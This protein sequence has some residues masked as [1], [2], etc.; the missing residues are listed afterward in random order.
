MYAQINLSSITLPG[1]IVSMWKY[2][3]R[4]KP[5]SLNMCHIIEDCLKRGFGDRLLVPC[6]G[7]N[8]YF[9]QNHSSRLK[10]RP[11]TIQGDHKSDYYA[12]QDSKFKENIPI[13]QK[14]VEFRTKLTQQETSIMNDNYMR[15]VGYQ[16]CNRLIWTNGMDG[17]RHQGIPSSNNKQ[18]CFGSI[19]KPHLEKCDVV[20]K[21]DSEKWFDKIKPTDVNKHHE[22]YKKYV[23]AK[24]QLIDKNFGI[25]LPTTCGYSRVYGSKT[26]VQ[27]I[28][29][30]YVQTFFQ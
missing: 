18:R 23:I 5:I 21:N 16:T 15:F 29:G 19:N 14:F 2:A 11:K 20:K 3:K 12:R 1:T 4:K 13:I 8:C 27:Y 7:V 6:A 22:I 28:Y 9:G 10:N 24:L 30:S 17:S 26:R 25:G